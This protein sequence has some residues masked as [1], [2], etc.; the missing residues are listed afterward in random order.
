MKIRTAKAITAFLAGCLCLGTLG[1]G[2]CEKRTSLQA[3]GSKDFQG[4]LKAAKMISTSSEKNAA[5]EGL[6]IMAA[7]A[8]ET[9]VVTQAISAINLSSARNRAAERAAPLLAQ[10]GNT[11]DAISVVKLITDTR[12]RNRVL[13]VI[14]TQEETRAD[15]NSEGQVSTND[16][17]SF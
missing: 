1:L 2:G 17:N 7:E 11:E 12:V 9:K 13:A 3:E 16:E 14:A 6:A 5:L 8:G 15:T 10:G 4:R